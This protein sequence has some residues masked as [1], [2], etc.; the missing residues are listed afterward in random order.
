MTFTFTQEQN[1]QLQAL[2]KSSEIAFQ[3]NQSAEGVFT[4]AYAKVYDY[5]SQAIVFGNDAFFIPADG[6]PRNVWQWVEGAG[7]VNVSG[8]AFSG[9]IRNYT[10]FQ[11]IL[12]EGGPMAVGEMQRASNTVASKFLADI[13]VRLN[14]PDPAKWTMPNIR[15]IGENDAGAAASVVFDG[16][17]A[18]WAGTLLFP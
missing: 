1:D 5:I 18:P 2:I 12:R 6:I 16:D 11:H 10:N 8:G 3:A 14:K 9:F 4:A 17:F 13:L 15:E 7:D